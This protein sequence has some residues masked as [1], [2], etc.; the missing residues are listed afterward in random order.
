[1]PGAATKSA[2]MLNCLKAAVEKRDLELDIRALR[3]TIAEL[4]KRP[5][6]VA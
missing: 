3:A 1:M 6:G 4:Q 2:N 5:R